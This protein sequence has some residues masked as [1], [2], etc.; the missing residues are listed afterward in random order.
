LCGELFEG[1]D[2]VEDRGGL[3]I[4]VGEVFAGSA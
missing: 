4:E 3:G 2:A 1:A